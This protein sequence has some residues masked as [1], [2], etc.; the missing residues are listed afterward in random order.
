[1]ADKKDK[2]D[3][4]GNL[5]DL[6][7]AA[8]NRLVSEV[9]NN[10]DIMVKDGQIV[11]DPKRKSRRDAFE[12]VA[13]Q[14]AQ[15]G[16]AMGGRPDAWPAQVGKFLSGQ[17]QNR[18][19]NRLIT[20]QGLSDS[21]ARMITPEMIQSANEAAFKRSQIR[22]QNVQAVKDFESIQNDRIKTAADV[23]GQ[24][25]GRMNAATSAAAEV[26][27]QAKDDREAAKP[28]TIDKGTFI[29]ETRYDPETGTYIATG[30]FAKD[31]PKFVE[32]QETGQD[33][34]AHMVTYEQTVGKDGA[35]AYRPVGDVLSAQHLN[36]GLGNSKDVAAITKDVRRIMIQEAINTAVGA[37][38]KDQLNSL[39]NDPFNTGANETRILQYL[40]TKDRQQ[41]EQDISE[42]VQLIAQGTPMQ[43]AILQARSNNSGQPNPTTQTTTGGKKSVW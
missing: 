16:A 18:V 4:M 21:E 38:P 10:P 6:T 12:N 30:Q 41:L 7:A 3:L 29:Q 32:V 40:P 13:G 43:D 37:A 34:K 35:I 11:R 26:R 33:G 25:T 1:M 20:G 2:P 42:A 9:I 24:V 19:Y 8:N 27:N 22:N 15:I 39:F 31:A 23:E 36:A 5:K 28:V 17:A 14:I